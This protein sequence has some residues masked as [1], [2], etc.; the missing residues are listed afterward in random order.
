MTGRVEKGTVTAVS[1]STVRVLRGS[2]GVTPLL[3]CAFSETPSP[4]DEVAFTLFSDGTGVVLFD[5]GS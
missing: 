2:S 3:P 4:G 5:F 1:G